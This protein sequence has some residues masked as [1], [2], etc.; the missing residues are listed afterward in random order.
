MKKTLVATVIICLCLLLGCSFQHHSVDDFS[1]DEAYY[2]GFEEGVEYAL[3]I[4]LENADD[5][6]LYMNIEDV[7]ESIRRYYKN[8]STVDIDEIRDCIVF[9]PDF[10]RYTINE[11]IKE[12]IDQNME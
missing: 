2:F 10:D 12:I 11:L 3:S 1:D 8:D 6:D 7:E 5:H 9:H 4:I